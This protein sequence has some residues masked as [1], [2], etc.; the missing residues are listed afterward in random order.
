[1]QLLLIGPSQGIRALSQDSTLTEIPPSRDTPLEV[2]HTYTHTH[3]QWS[4]VK[5]FEKK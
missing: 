5:G 2:T 3:S 4:M 1:M